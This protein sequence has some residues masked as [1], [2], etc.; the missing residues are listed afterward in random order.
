MHHLLT[1]LILIL[2]LF[3]GCTGGGKPSAKQTEEWIQDHVA[4]LDAGDNY[5]FVYSAVNTDLLLERLAGRGDVERIALEDTDVSTKGMEY[6]STFPNLK[7]L[8]FN[9]AKGLDQESLDLLVECK[10]LEWLQLTNEPAIIATLRSKMPNCDIG[11]HWKL[12]E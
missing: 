9:V 8:S 12:A 6:L 7:Q 10:S 3:T 4:K 2:I 5:V 1:G 11:V